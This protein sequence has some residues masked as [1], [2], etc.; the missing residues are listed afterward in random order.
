LKAHL[1]KILHAEAAHRNQHGGPAQQRLHGHSYRIEILASGT[2]DS[3]IGWVVDFAE[4]KELFRPVY[5]QLDHACLNDLPGLEQD[6]R[7]PALE[8]WIVAQ[9]QPAPPWLDG[10]RVGIVGDL[11][12]APVRLPAREAERLPERIGFTFE[13]AQ[14]LPQL[15][16]EHHC[17]RVHGHSYRL[18]IG[19]AQLDRAGTDLGQLYETLDHQYLNEVPGLE[20][21]TCERICAWIWQ[22]LV[23]R[24][25][26]PTVVVI[27]ET[28]TARC[29]YY[30][31]SE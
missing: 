9:L 19:T 12:F 18:E 28:G 1:V 26:E 29:L 17:Q 4:L 21:A 30:G 3:G 31:E 16:S 8:Q 5:A 14:S 24:G 13:A 2:P 20:C 11:T 10:V 27:Q 25:H 23:E 7:L 22:W 6:T 15:P